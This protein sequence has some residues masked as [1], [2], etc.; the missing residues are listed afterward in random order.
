MPFL[1]LPRMTGMKAGKEI[2]FALG[3]ARCVLPE[4]SDTITKRHRHH[5]AT[6]TRELAIGNL[7]PMGVALPPADRPEIAR[8]IQSI[9][10]EKEWSQR[11]LSRRAGFSA[12]SQLG[13][14][15]RRLEEGSE[16]ELETLMAVAA[17][18]GVP[19][20]W[21][22]TGRGESHLD[23]VDPTTAAERSAVLRKADRV[24][25]LRTALGLSP[26]GLVVSARQLPTGRI[27]AIEDGTYSLDSP[28]GRIDQEQ[29]ARGF[30]LASR[31]F[32]AYL[33]G[34][35]S[36]RDAARWA[37]Q[38]RSNLAFKM[39]GLGPTSRHPLPVVELRAAVPAWDD[40]LG[41]AFDGQSHAIAD[42]DA[43]R[44]LQ[45][46]SEGLRALDVEL[47]SFARLALDV[48]AATRGRAKRTVTA[49]ELVEILRA[50]VSRS[51]AID[52][53]APPEGD[54]VFQRS[55]AMPG[56]KDTHR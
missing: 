32:R 26:A 55:D 28:T 47:S 37:K 27:A 46:T 29:L 50:L 44:G 12:L 22:V 23:P 43:A 13:N 40:A 36:L 56:E 42:L 19:L 53:T 16:V 2:D 3:E 5:V 54:A 39:L 33:T 11:E 21:L 10:K 20:T 31:D 38:T 18:A 14:V 51:S 30:G 1:D 17:G 48:S 24:F 4:Q 45:Q 6:L 7:S 9:L 41:K 52:G 8:R 49:Q 34:E 25:A 35:V 15:L